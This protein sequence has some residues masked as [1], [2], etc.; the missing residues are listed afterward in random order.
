MLNKIPKAN[1]LIMGADL[2]AFIGTRSSDANDN[3]DPS[4]GLLSLHG[5]PWRNARGEL[6]IRILTQFQM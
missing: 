1:I 3:K 2:K 4:V 6:I 5:N